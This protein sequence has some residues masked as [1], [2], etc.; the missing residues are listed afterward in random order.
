MIDEMIGMWL[1]KK[2]DALLGWICWKIQR[3]KVR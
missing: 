2:P 1:T 3:G